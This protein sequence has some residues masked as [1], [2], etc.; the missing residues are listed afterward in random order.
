MFRHE[1]FIPMGT[2]MR[3]FHVRAIDRGRFYEE[4]V[5]KS[6][7]TFVFWTCL[8]GFGP[9]HCGCSIVDTKN[10]WLGTK[11]LI[12]PQQARVID[13]TNRLV[14]LDIDRQRIKTVRNMIHP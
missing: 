3:S 6:F 7:S 11:V 10:W 9:S 13:W 8:P 1:A 12:S 4:R 5:A 14:D 2:D